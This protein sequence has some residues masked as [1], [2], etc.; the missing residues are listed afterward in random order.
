MFALAPNVG[1]LFLLQNATCIL[2]IS[3]F[4]LAGN[5]V[6]DF[7]IYLLLFTIFSRF[8]PHMSSFGI[9]LKVEG[10]S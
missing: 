7:L 8:H 1:F 10:K 9:K 4:T 5:P 3:L 6:I 2:I